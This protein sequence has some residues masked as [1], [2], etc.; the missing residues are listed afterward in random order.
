M[1]CIRYHGGVAQPEENL[2]QAGERIPELAAKAPGGDESS[3]RDLLPLVY[4]ELRLLAQQRMNAER[5]DHTLNATALVHEAWLKIGAS[6][7]AIPWANRA[8]F[9]AAAAEAMRQILLDHAKSRGRVKRGGGAKRVPL[10][11][12]DIADTWNFTET[13]RLDEAIRRLMSEDAAV[14]EVV[15]LRFFAGL[16]NEQAAEA[17]GVSQATIKR[18][19]EF[20][21][22]WLFRE[23]SRGEDDEPRGR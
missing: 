18:R 11:V 13:V 7:R 5:P 4:R 22:T 21:R 16:T 10:S 6:E 8:H 23:M 2:M 17:L 19:W 1:V 12:A 15:R 14:G 20:G 3:G 9:Y